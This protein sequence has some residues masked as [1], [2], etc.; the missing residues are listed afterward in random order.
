[1]RDGDSANFRQI[2]LIE[3]AHGHVVHP[4]TYGNY[5]VEEILAWNEDTGTV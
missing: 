2:A 3:N 5:Q 4:L 1:L